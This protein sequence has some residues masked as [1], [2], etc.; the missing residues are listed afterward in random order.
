[1]NGSGSLRWPDGSCV[2]EGGGDEELGPLVMSDEQL[3]EDFKKISDMKKLKA[4]CK[5]FGLGVNGK[6]SELIKRLD[7]FRD[8]QRL[9]K[10]AQFH[11]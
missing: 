4:R 7:D 1:M 8:A 6:R 3:E 9:A 5:K 2:E 11:R 10:M